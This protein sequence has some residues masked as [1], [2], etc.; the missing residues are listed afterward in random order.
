ME[1][2]DLNYLIALED[3]LLQRFGGGNDRLVAEA[4]IKTS[5]KRALVHELFR[6]YGLKHKTVI[7]K[8]LVEM[9]GDV[10]RY[11]TDSGG[12]DDLCWGCVDDRPLR[13]QA[14]AKLVLVEL[15]PSNAW[16][17]PGDRLSDPAKSS[18]DKG[19]EFLG[20]HWEVRSASLGNYMRS[21]EFLDR[22][23]KIVY[24][25]PNNT[26]CLKSRR[27]GAIPEILDTKLK[28]K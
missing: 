25:G 24:Q 13:W 7:T 8:Q 17:P 21:S 22:R 18:C 5:A 4:V 27:F 1:Q 16:Q 12:E 23:R 6:H 9:P 19:A 10:S 14:L 2:D 26:T 20:I 11:P 3:Q 15:P 28:A